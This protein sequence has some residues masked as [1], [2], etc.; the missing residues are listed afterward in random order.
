MAYGAQ[1]IVLKLRIVRISLADFFLIIKVCRLPPLL[2]LA[3]L[4][5]S[6]PW[7]SLKGDLNVLFM[8]ST[9]I[10]LQLFL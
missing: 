10:R 7:F 9:G 8:Y 3:M 1:G 5:F 2:H 6:S 4:N